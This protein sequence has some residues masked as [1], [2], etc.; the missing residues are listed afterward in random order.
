M[1]K[2]T[3][4]LRSLRHNLQQIS[5]VIGRNNATW[6]VVTK[7]LCG[8]QDI[9]RALQ[10]LGV[11]SVADSRLGNLSKIK[12]AVTEFETWYLRLPHLSAIKSIVSLADISLNSE[13][14]MI[15]ALGKEAVAQNKVHRVVIMIE[16]GDLREGILPGS[17]SDFYETV[18]EIEGIEVIGIGAQ[19]GCLTGAMPNEDQMAQLGLYRELLELKFD[20]KIPIISAGST[21]FLPK[22][23][24]G[25]NY[26]AVNHYRIGEGLF[27]GTNLVTGE[28]IE[29][30]L[31]DVV[32]LDVEI[33]E[34]KEKQLTSSVETV[35]SAPFEGQETNPADQ[36]MPGQRGVRALLTVGHLDTNISGLTPLVSEYQVAGGSSDITVMNLGSNP[37]RLKLGDTVT[38]KTNY[39]AFL[40]LMNDP[41]IEKTVT[42]SLEEF[43]SE[44]SKDWNLTVPKTLSDEQMDGS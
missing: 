25:G 9:L 38:F 41:Y 24:E 21:I 20:R 34:I 32:L 35:G 30:L 40:G 2:V 1:N 37:N 23:F 14:Q 42:P 13:I 6:S 22:L 27:L 36:P 11:H 19:I 7:S 33:A 12:E 31:D 28:R 5:S 17:L 44:L 3:I 4:N 26:P 18:F 15:R 39:S 43:K 29:Q 10:M 8:N 16:L